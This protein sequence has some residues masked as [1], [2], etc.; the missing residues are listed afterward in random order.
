MA[1]QLTKRK[2][3]ELPEDKVEK[4][5]ELSNQITPE[6]VVT[7]SGDIDSQISSVTSDVLSYSKTS[8]LGSDVS[9]IMSDISMQ[10]KEMDDLN[11]DGKPL[12]RFL[13]N[14]PFA[15]KIFNFKNK[16]V[17][18]AES[19]SSTFNQYSKSLADMK[20]RSLLSTAT[21]MEIS[22]SAIDIYDRTLEYI[23][24]FDIKI[25]DVKAE[26]DEMNENKENYDP[27]EIKEK[28]NFLSILDRQRHQHITNSLTLISL[29]DRV[30]DFKT[31]NEVL[32]Q[33]MCN[34]E[35]NILPNW[36]IMIAENIL[37]RQ[38]ELF[39]D[40]LTMMK[41]GYRETSISNAKTTASSN[42]K[43]QKSQAT[44]EIDYKTL[45]E[46][47]KITKEGIE[48]ATKIAIEETKARAKFG[49]E[50]IKLRESIVESM[51]DT[52]KINQ[53]VKK[54]IEEK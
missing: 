37:L 30:N 43:L 9:L 14:L 54:S 15:K 41:D 39:T 53:H 29:I 16:I 28:E 19:V 20:T 35:S 11:V 49:Q 46:A 38:Q 44:S 47:I 22:S 8:S 10:L 50:S 27:F 48:T 7:I 6:N 4:I 17:T 45:S 31:R 5:K 24:A 23:E 51:S 42:I 2:K 13:M 1:N 40:S 12:K 25:T 36:R 21:M 18:K 33:E 52:Q 32:Y 26:L 3:A 34:I